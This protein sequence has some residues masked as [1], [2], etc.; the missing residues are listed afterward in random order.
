LHQNNKKLSIQAHTAILKKNSKSSTSS[1]EPHVISFSTTA[2]TEATTEELEELETSRIK[3]W[4][5]TR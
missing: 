1:A 5:K 4:N 3:Y 2:R